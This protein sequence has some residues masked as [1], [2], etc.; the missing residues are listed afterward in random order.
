M[1]LCE[2]FQRLSTFSEAYREVFPIIGSACTEALKIEHEKEK[3]DTISIIM[4]TCGPSCWCR[5]LWWYLGGFGYGGLVAAVGFVAARCKISFVWL[6]RRQG[7]SRLAILAAY[8]K[9][10]FDHKAF[11]SGD[12]TY[13]PTKFFQRNWLLEA[14]FSL[15]FFFFFFFEKV[16]ASK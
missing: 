6:R 2:C 16:I 13:S 8:P 1:F 9:L 11:L 7:S 14:G 15:L 10:T 4:V 12:L 5:L 3:W